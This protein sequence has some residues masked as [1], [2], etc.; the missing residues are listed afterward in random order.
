MAKL[1]KFFQ[2]VLRVTF[3]F[4]WAPN[5]TADTSGIKQKRTAN[6]AQVAF[7]VKHFFLDQIQMLAKNLFGIADQ[8]KG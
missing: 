6:Q 5:S 7:S 2:H 3:Y 1:L 8:W 4:D